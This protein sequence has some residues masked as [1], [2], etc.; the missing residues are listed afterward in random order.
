MRSNFK[1]KL[2]TI[3]SFVLLE[4]LFIEIVRFFNWIDFFDFKLLRV[5]GLQLKNCLWIGLNCLEFSWFDIFSLFIEEMLKIGDDG[6]YRLIFDHHFLMMRVALLSSSGLDS[7]TH[8]DINPHISLFFIGKLDENLFVFLQKF[9]VFELLAGFP[10]VSSM[11]F[12]LLMQGKIWRIFWFD[13]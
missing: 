2:P 4:T 7:F 8:F 12:V 13:W 10:L 1:P 11:F 6:V 5:A 3:P 9:Y